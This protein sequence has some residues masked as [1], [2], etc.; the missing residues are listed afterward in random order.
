MN[1]KPT[2]QILKEKK[3]VGNKLKMS[4]LNNKTT[5]LWALFAPKIIDIKNKVNTDK[6]SMQIYNDSY[7]LNFNPANEF[8]K[9]ATVEVE[10]FSKEQESFETFILKSGQYA[11]FNYKGLSS[12]ARIFEYIFMKWLPSSKYSLDNRPHFEILGEKYKNNDLNSE[13]EIWIPIKDKS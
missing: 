7:F 9:W 8:K 10:N 4:L 1:I 11:V 6:I 12:D 5:T 2:I 3:L 13:E